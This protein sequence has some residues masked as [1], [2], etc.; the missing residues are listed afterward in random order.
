MQKI[1]CFIL[2]L[3]V[4]QLNAQ[5]PFIKTTDSYFGAS[6]RILA[7]RIVPVQSQGWLIFSS[8]SLRLSRYNNC[9]M[10]EWAKKYYMPAV[11]FGLYDFIRLNNGDYAFMNRISKG[12]VS[13]TSVTRIDPSGNIL[14]SKSYGDNTYEQY[15]YTLLEDNSGNLYI[16]GNMS[17]ITTSPIYN[18]LTKINANGILQWTQLYDHGGIWGGAIATSDNGFLLRTGSYLIKTDNNGFVS[19]TSLISSN[20]YYYLAPLEVNDG[21]IFTGYTS[22]GNYITFF[23]VDK[24]GNQ[25]WSG[26]KQLDI[27]HDPPKMYKTPA[28][29]IVGVFH[30]N[31]IIEFDT[32]LNVVKISSMDNTALLVGTEMCF[33]D[34]GTPLISGIDNSGMTFFAKLDNNYH[35]NCNMQAFPIIIST[36]P[37]TLN[38]SATNVTSYQFNEYVELYPV[39]TFSI[40]VFPYC[41]VSKT[42]ELGNDTSVCN[43]TTVNL[44]NHTTDIFQYY[45]WST[46]ETTSSITV[47]DSGIYILTAKDE[48]DEV[49]LTD[50]ISVHILKTPNAELGPDFVLC[51]NENRI[52]KTA[53]CDSCS[54]SWNT[55]SITDTIVVQQAGFYIVTVTENSG[56]TASDEIEILQSKC[57]CSIYIPKAFTPNKDNKNEVFQSYNYCDL[58]EYKL[59]IFNRW[60]QKIFSTD[61][62]QSFWDGTF[63]NKEAP[64]D[65]Y[66]YS[67]E[68]TSVI[69]GK[70]SNPLKKNGTVT[71]IR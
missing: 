43:G 42:L 36:Y 17:H 2:M 26:G 16:Y 20:T 33:Q 21:Y 64:S 68:Y 18:F 37:A 46:G 41:N 6:S 67:L 65:V 66:V 19:W 57:E 23:K 59:I 29:N 53:S 45:Y 69:K 27:S 39:D 35:S 1:F 63:N 70:L 40:H 71:L 30:S 47:S 51:E 7:T 25:L 15:P 54:Y 5:N 13:I 38:F 56:C 52:V 24:S 34:N 62:P 9:G 44:Y 55:G 22:P 48:C 4:H 28:G 8:D 10:N 11:T 32:D 14:W 60:G 50:S 49:V 58:H 3:C 31:K 12:I 61:N